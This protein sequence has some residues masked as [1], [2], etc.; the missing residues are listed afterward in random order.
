V[1]P[2]ADNNDAPDE[3]TD[4]LYTAVGFAVL[5]FQRMMYVGR[6]VERDARTRM[7]SASVESRDQVAS[8]ADDVDAGLKR[9]CDAPSQPVAEVAAIA[10]SATRHLR[11]QI[12]DPWVERP[13]Q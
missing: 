10:L 3:L 9:L 8:I 13:P 5:G 1:D 11:E 4:A 6:Q 7:N 12:L 2:A